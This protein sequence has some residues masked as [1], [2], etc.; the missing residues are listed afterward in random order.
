KSGTWAKTTLYS[1]DG[2]DGSFAYA[3]VVFDATG[4]LWGTTSGYGSDLGSVYELVRGSNRQWTIKVLQTFH[5]IEVNGGV[6]FDAGGN[7]YSTAVHGGNIGAC[8]QG[9]GE[10]F[11][12][13]P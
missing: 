5:D 2:K 8:T 4:N 12:V 9:C 6:V 11:E 7:V 3:G 13:R 1:F 10:A